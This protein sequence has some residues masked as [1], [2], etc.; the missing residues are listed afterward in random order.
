MHRSRYDDT[1][2]AVATGQSNL[3][4]IAIIRVSGPDAISIVEKHFRYTLKDSHKAKFGVFRNEAGGAI[5]DVIVLAMKGPKS[6][7]GEDVVEVHCH[8]GFIQ[9]R[10]ICE[11][12]CASGCRLAEPGEFTRRAVLNNRLSLLQAEAINHVIHA[13]SEVDAQ[14]ALMNCHGLSTNRFVQLRQEIVTVL[15]YIE[16]S[17]DF[18][19]EDPA[20]EEGD[21]EVMLRSLV[22]RLDALK[23]TF[24]RGRLL[25]NGP[26]IVITGDVNV[27]KSSL[28]NALLRSERAIVTHIPGTTRDLIEEGLFID[29]YSFRLVDTAG[30]RSTDCLVEQEGMKRAMS[31]A[32]QADIVLDVR[33]IRNPRKNVDDVDKLRIL[34]ANKSD[35]SDDYP[36]NGDEVCVSA[37]NGDG[38][39]KLTKKLIEAAQKL[40]G[41]VQEDEVILFTERQF[42]G[43]SKALSAIER[44]LTAHQE[45]L[46]DVV[47]DETRDGAAYIASIIGEVHNEDVLD[48]M[49]TTFCLGK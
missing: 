19:D 27:G 16:A 15:A 33:D 46:L 41:T 13:T 5:D 2:C 12:L 32:E 18:P 24:K 17:L 29:G 43:V 37:L 21:V 30:L 14:A 20:I 10:R 36:S 48:E 3:S 38:L 23:G 31:T 22:S 28:F 49:F 26:R 11:A 34:V 6:Y 8:G 1:I 7:T 25:R 44:A 40:A 45:R 47:A 42:D 39:D 9:P 4:A 35:L